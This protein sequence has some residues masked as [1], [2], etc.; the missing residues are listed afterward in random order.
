MSDRNI[1]RI[2]QN[3]PLWMKIEIS[4]SRINNAIDKF[5]RNEL[6]VSFSGGKD[7][8]VLHYLV[9]EVELE[10]FGDIKIARVFDD[11]GLEFPELR[12]FAKTIANVIIRPDMNFK[13]VLEKYGYPVISKTQAMAIRKLRTQNLSDEY[14]NKLLYG[15]ERGTAGKLSN[16]YHYLL[17]APFKISEQC[18]DV[19]KKRPFHA[20][21]K[22]TNRIPMTGVMASESNN[23]ETRYLNDGGCNAFNIK[24]PQSK[25]LGIWLETDIL[26][27]LKTNNLPYASVYGEIVAKDDKLTTTGEKRT[28]CVFCGFGANRS[29][30]DR[31]IRLKETHPNLYDYCMNKLNL[32][33]VLDYLNIKH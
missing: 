10:R 19:M 12:Q 8:T 33:E 6:Y 22:N 23:R 7:S 15:D 5:G 27:Y 17:N 16:K 31:F 24:N 32:K 21:E 9:A 11:T 2:K 3:Y 1:L 14:R 25:P 28:G 29:S 20:Y 4:K 13:Q 30:D 26:E 18:C